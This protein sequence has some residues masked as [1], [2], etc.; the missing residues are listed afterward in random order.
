MCL[1]MAALFMATASPTYANKE[2][3]RGFGRGVSGGGH[4]ISG[5][6][7]GGGR[8][9]NSTVNSRYSPTAED[10]AHDKKVQNF[11]QEF[12]EWM[13][14][15]LFKGWRAVFMGAEKA[16]T[17]LNKQGQKTRTWQGK[18]TGYPSSRGIFSGGTSMFNRRNNK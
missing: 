2:G 7:R 16:H 5:S 9:S 17:A 14:F 1:I 6:N 8:I 10:K 13:F 18:Q 4:M 3:E 12:A 11:K 15:P